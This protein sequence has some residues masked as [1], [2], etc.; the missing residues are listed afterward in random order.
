MWNSGPGDTISWKRIRT[1][2]PF[3]KLEWKKKGPGAMGEE[4]GKTIPWPI[5]R[6]Q[7]ASIVEG[8]FE[9]IL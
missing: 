6:S 3:R 7:I 1:F 9:A 5:T 8:G 4:P 2:Q